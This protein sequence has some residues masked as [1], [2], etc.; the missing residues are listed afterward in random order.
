MRH[1]VEVFERRYEVD[2]GAVGLVRRFGPPPARD[3]RP[4]RR[5]RGA[6]R[7]RGSVAADVRALASCSSTCSGSTDVG[8][9]YPHRV[10]YHPTCHSLRMLRV[11]DKPLRLLRWCAA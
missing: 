1:H 5:G 2:G 11:G 9:A 6:R 8:A 10:T 7:A 3:G 4:P